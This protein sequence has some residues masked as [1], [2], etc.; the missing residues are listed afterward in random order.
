MQIKIFA[1]FRSAFQAWSRKLCVR[2]EGS[3][4][5]SPRHRLQLA[6][7]GGV[8]REGASGGATQEELK[9]ELR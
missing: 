3:L 2:W 5:L 6:A 9:A 4:S 7:Q 1:S 8:A